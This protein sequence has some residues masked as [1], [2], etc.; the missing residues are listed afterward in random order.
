MLLFFTRTEGRVNVAFQSDAWLSTI[1]CH[2]LLNSINSSTSMHNILIIFKE[3]ELSLLGIFIIYLIR[4]FSRVLD[5]SS[6]LCKHMYN[7]TIN[8]FVILF[9]A[10]Y[11]LHLSLHKTKGG[12]F[13]GRGLP[14]VDS[15]FSVVDVSIYLRTDVIII[16]LTKIGWI[17]L[18]YAGRRGRIKKE[19]NVDRFGEIECAQ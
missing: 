4:T 17:S 15:S 11:F 3:N 6:V 12:G 13:W 5:T 16:Y 18:P 9:T 1:L 19:F 7:N 2:N 10:F 14:M 8:I